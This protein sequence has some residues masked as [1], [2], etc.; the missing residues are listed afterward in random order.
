MS[1]LLVPIF[2]FPSELTKLYVDSWLIS[3]P[4]GQTL[5]KLVFFLGFIS[6]QVSIQSLVLIAVDRFG[7]DGI[8]PPFSTHQFKAVPLLHSR[9][10]DRRYGSHVAIFV[11]LQTYWIPRT[12]SM[13]EEVERSI[14][15]VIVRGTLPSSTICCIFLYPCRFVDHTLFHQ[16][17]KSQVTEDFRRTICQHWGTTCEKK[18]KCAKDRWP[19]QSCQCLYCVGCLST[20]SV[21]KFPYMG[22]GRLIDCVTVLFYD[23]LL[24]SCKTSELEP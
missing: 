14:W 4:L 16:P 23:K 1:D 18:Q 24:T 15:R 10:M 11:R 6:I 9:H 13:R 17:C 20:L 21:A 8:S 7:A 2:L 5:C 12:T 22:C 19:S 3:G